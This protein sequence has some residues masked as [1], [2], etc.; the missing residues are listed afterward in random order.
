MGLMW[1]DITVKDLQI[2]IGDI[3]SFK[4]AFKVIIC[5]NIVAIPNEIL[6]TM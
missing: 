3:Y 4:L 6:K 5:V 2:I 1:F